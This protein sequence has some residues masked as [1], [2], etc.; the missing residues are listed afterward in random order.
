MGAGQTGGEGGQESTETKTEAEDC[1]SLGEGCGLGCLCTWKQSS[2]PF[3]D[4][5]N[6]EHQLYVCQVQRCVLFP[7]DL[8]GCTGTVM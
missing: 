3:I 8:P 4:S 1:L 6:I 5:A 2:L 7:E